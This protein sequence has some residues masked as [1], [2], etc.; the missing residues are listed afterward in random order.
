VGSVRYAFLDGPT[1]LAMA[2]RGGAIEHLENS[3]PAFEACVAMG[4]R[5]LETDVRVT[6]DGVPVVFHDA[7]LDRVTDRT[8]RVDQLSWS[9]LAGARIG[10]RE[11]I[12]RLEEL[13]GAWPDVRFNLDIKAAGV[14]A[15]LARTVRR[16]GV[17]DRICLGSFSDARVAAARRVFGPEVCTSL[18]P[19]GVAALRL[20]S[21]SPRAAGLVRIPAAQLEGHLR[22]A[23]RALVDERFIAA[24][25]ARGLQVHV[26]TV[27][28]EA[29]ATALLDLGVDGV[30][31]DRPAMLRDLLQRRGQWVPR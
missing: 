4:Y 7:T 21:Y 22:A 17:E 15:P 9:E 18:G 26:W 1:P 6:A 2:H 19:R 23:G 25:H 29:E 31:T 16:L 28:T 24:A 12:L 27:D 13:L 11:P 10:G 14:V 5:Y 3:M 20:S 8:G 30:M